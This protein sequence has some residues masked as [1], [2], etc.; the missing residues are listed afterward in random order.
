M[1]RKR[2]DTEMNTREANVWEETRAPNRGLVSLFTERS[3][4]YTR[5]EREENNQRVIVNLCV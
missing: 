2:E 4:S 3:K 5:G 1:S